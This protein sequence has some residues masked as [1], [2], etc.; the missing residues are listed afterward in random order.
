M[1]RPYDGDVPQGLPGVGLPLGQV[2]PRPSTTSLPRP[3]TAVVVAPVE[4]PSRATS[5]P[6]A[7][8]PGRPTDDRP[9]V[10]V[11][12]VDAVADEVGHAH[13]VKIRLLAPADRR[14]RATVDRRATSPDRLLGGASP[15]A[16]GET[17]ALGALDPSAEGDIGRVVDVVAIPTREAV[18]TRPDAAVPA[19]VRRGHR[20]VPRTETIQVEE[21]PVDVVTV[22]VL[23]VAARLEVPRHGVAV[24]VT[25]VLGRGRGRHEGETA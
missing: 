16:P 10:P 8:R 9:A 3:T 1:V 13:A 2:G 19:T 5:G 17:A 20:P 11:V 25:P 6:V 12:A 22:L 24:G 14:P 21:R 18:H 15:V 23:A 4:T 7:A